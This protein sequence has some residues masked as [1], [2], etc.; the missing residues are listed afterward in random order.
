VDVG[1]LVE[2]AVSSSYAERVIEASYG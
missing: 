2:I 1:Y